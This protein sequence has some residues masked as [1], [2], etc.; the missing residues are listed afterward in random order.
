MLRTINY[1]MPTEEEQKAFFANYRPMSREEIAEI[2]E[3]QRVQFA[4]EVRQVIEMRHREGNTV[5]AA[6]AFKL[7]LDKGITYADLMRLVLEEE[8]KERNSNT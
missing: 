6:F 4:D 8:Q 7:G 2:H 3:R 1:A 5:G